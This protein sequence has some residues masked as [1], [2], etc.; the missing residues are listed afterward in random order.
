[1]LVE[2]KGTQQ[3][4][5]IAQEMPDRNGKQCR[6]RWHNQL[7][8]NLSKCEWTP[9]ED[10]ILLE[11][12][13][14]LGNK[15]A[16][17]AK[18]LPGRTDNSVKNHW[19]SAVHREF[20]LRN[21][22]VEQPKPPAAARPPKPPKVPKASKATKEV[23][24]KPTAQEM[25]AIKQLLQD[26]PESPLANLL[27][28][29]LS[30]TPNV[31][32]LKKHQPAM[33]ALVGL[34]RARS[35]EAMQL[36]VLQLHSSVANSASASTV[37]APSAHPSPGGSSS[38]DVALSP[39]ALSALLTPSGTGYR[40]DFE[41]ALAAMRD[42]IAEPIED[43]L[44]EESLLAMISSPSP[45]PPFGGFDSE[46][47]SARPGRS[48][49]GPL[50]KRQFPPPEAISGTDADEASQYKLARPKHLNAA[51]AQLNPGSIGGTPSLPSSHLSPPVVSS[52]LP[53]PNAAL[54][55]PNLGDRGGAPTG[56]MPPPMG[57]ERQRSVNLPPGRAL[58]DL[59]VGEVPVANGSAPSPDSLFAG[60]PSLSQAPLSALLSAAGFR[61][62]FG[63]GDIA[64]PLPN[65][66]LNGGD[67][68]YGSSAPT[69]APH[70]SSNALISIPAP[71][72]LTYGTS[73]ILGLSPSSVHGFVGDAAKLL[74]EALASP[75]S[76]QLS[77]ARK[78]P[79]FQ[80]FTSRFG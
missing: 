11:G 38:L 2:L 9:E 17:I 18:L 54:F 59:T 49:R 40:V 43:P 4:A 14:R 39:M 79:R 1:M 31:V 62:G 73:S 10:R 58:P 8:N 19:N 33:N 72:S 80:S 21:G 69:P 45:R 44:D 67:H 22:W 13:Q 32:A 12:Q 77:A 56:A 25:E 61:M 15:W 51:S 63:F 20:R 6:E 27:Q 42:G 34:L 64:S 29:A 5:Q 65:S 30:G 48:P 24:L 53:S 23:A 52:K 28:G 78:S 75:L 74:E 37:G 70:S 66:G 50:G 47:P 3:W 16:E 41:A 35:R 7:N 71:P 68:V 36:A 55:T 57:G 60:L 76:S 26:N 46:R